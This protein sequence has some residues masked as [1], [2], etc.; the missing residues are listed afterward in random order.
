MWVVKD[1]A[2][3][4]QYGF[5]I[6]KHYDEDTQEYIGSSWQRIVISEFMRTIYLEVYEDDVKFDGAVTESD[7]RVYLEDTFESIED[8]KWQYAVPILSKLYQEGIIEW[9]K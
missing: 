7:H 4:A 8:E 1:T 2:M 3:L 5:K 6:E 9:R